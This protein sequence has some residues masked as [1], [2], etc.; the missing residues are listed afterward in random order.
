MFT[1][2]KIALMAAV[3]AIAG[4]STGQSARADTAAH[5]TRFDPA[6]QAIQKV[7]F[8]QR[9]YLRWGGA[10]PG[11]RY[12][13]YPSY[14]YP[15]YP[16]SGYDAP[17]VDSQYPSYDDPAY[18]DDGYADGYSQYPSYGDPAYPDYDYGF[19]PDGYDDGQR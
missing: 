13:Q 18:D 3:C 10:Y 8:Y 6:P 17:Y 15:A 11:Y 1:S 9:P 14:G 5:L 19:P 16:D 7:Q 12:S 2:S 4:L